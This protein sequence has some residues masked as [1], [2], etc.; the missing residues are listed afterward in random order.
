M[1]A[2]LG[3]AAPP[4]ARIKYDLLLAVFGLWR[5]DERRWHHRL[6]YG[7]SL[8]A[9]SAR[10]WRRSVYA[11]F[12]DFAVSTGPAAQRFLN[13]SP[14]GQLVLAE[15]DLDAAAARFGMVVD[16]G[17]SR[18][19]PR[20]SSYWDPGAESDSE[21]GSESDDDDPAGFKRR[22]R[23]RSKSAKAVIKRCVAERQEKALKKSSSSG[24][25]KALRPTDKWLKHLR[26]S[27]LADEAGLSIFAVMCGCWWPCGGLRRSGAVR[28]CVCG[29]EAGPDEVTTHFVLGA[30]KSGKQCPAA[31]D[32]RDEWRDRVGAA[33]SRRG[34][35]DWL[36]WTPS[37]EVVALC[38]GNGGNSKDRDLDRELPFIFTET[39]GAWAAKERDRAV[40]RMYRTTESDSESGSDGEEED[41][42]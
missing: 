18:R 30:D 29:Y 17:G 21:S 38:L 34:A 4:R 11:A 24:L 2:I 16:D 36:S 19:P 15:R 14:T 28:A 26:R 22:A 35:V 31:A 9:A 40:P 3:H 27:L 5:L 1:V 10:P 12:R 32:A 8:E 39:F 7:A 42:I 23:R 13:S 33:L 41:D 25:F 6:R 20:P 37:I